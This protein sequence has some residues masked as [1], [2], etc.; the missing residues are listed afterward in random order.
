MDMK[1]IKSSIF[2]TGFMGAGKST[3]GKCLAELLGYEFVDLDQKIVAREGRSIADIFSSEGEKY[4]RDCESR[5]LASLSKE[6][7]SVYATGG[8][9]VEREANRAM[10]RQKGL[11]VYLNASWDTLRERLHRSKDRPLVNQDKGWDTVSQLW[12]NRQS[13]Y[14]DADIIVETDGRKPFEVAS[15]IVNILKTEAGS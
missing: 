2:L 14:Q 11:I 7:T 5:L 12:S 13:F 9:I 1:T 10:M 3:T 8:G 6:A 15:D 4:F